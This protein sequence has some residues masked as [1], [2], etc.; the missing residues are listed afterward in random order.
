MPAGL[1][2]LRINDTASKH[3]L[4][5]ACVTV[6]CYTVRLYLFKM[7]NLANNTLITSDNKRINIQLQ[8]AHPSN[9]HVCSVVY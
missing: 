7:L 1:K 5:I 6:S 4:N 2:V 9:L 3:C 8:L